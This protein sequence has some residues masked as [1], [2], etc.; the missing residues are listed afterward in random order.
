MT[1]KDGNAVIIFTYSK[2]CTVS[3]RDSRINASESPLAKPTTSDI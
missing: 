2:E 3:S 1:A